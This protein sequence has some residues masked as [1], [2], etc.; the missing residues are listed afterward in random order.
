MDNTISTRT[1]RCFSNNKP[2]VT[3]DLKELPNKKK[4]SFR[5]GDRELLRSVQ[6]QLKVKI[7]DDKEM[8]RKKLKNKLQQDNIRYVWSG[9]KNI[10]GS[11]QKEDQTDEVRTEQIK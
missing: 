2:C 6:K 9:I 1:V 5:E 10:T 3:C 8:Y 11:K 4:R 7:R